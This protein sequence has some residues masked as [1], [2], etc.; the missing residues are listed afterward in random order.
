MLDQLKL[1][2]ARLF[3]QELALLREDKML[4][5]I[6]LQVEREHQVSLVKESSKKAPISKLVRKP[7]TII[8]LKC[9]Y[10]NNNSEPIMLK[11]DMDKTANLTKASRQMLVTNSAIFCHQ[12]S[13]NLKS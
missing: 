11:E 10:N 2:P 9:L 6:L 4:A 8:I 1:F 5:I 13:S 12:K 7:E 3:H